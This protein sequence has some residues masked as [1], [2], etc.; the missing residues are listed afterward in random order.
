MKKFWFDIP[1]SDV[2]TKRYLIF[3]AVV[4]AIWLVIPMDVYVL[5]GLSVTYFSWNKIKYVIHEMHMTSICPKS[6][7]GI[8]W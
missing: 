5:A 4:D 6:E 3:F 2:V 1:W 8:L 7:T